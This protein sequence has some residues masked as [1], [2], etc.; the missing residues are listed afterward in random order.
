MV[1]GAEVQIVEGCQDRNMVLHVFILPQLMKAAIFAAQQINN[2]LIALLPP[3]GTIDNQHT[4]ELQC[5]LVDVGDI[6]SFLHPRL[7]FKSILV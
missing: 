7:D 6:Q 2:H 5:S 4:P 3:E 1:L